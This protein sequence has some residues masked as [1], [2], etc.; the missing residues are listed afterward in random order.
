MDRSATACT[1]CLPKFKL[2]MYVENEFVMGEENIIEGTLLQLPV[3]GFAWHF[4]SWL[5]I[6]HICTILLV[7]GSSRHSCSPKRC[8]WSN[9]SSILYCHLA[10]LHR[11]DNKLI[12]LTL[13]ENYLTLFSP[14]SKS[15]FTWM[16]N[17]R[18]RRTSLTVIFNII[19]WR[20]IRDRSDSFIIA[21]NQWL[22]LLNPIQMR[23]SYQVQYKLSHCR[24]SV[25]SCWAQE[26][27]IVA[28]LLREILSY[29]PQDFHGKRSP[30]STL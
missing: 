27:N 16:Q 13:G 12:T 7:H 18:M 24:S 3:Y 20:Q 22:I 11:T 1:R 17:A 26:K 8:T 19:I 9:S 29:S 4:Y 23:S 21:K 30:Y 28:P 5:C 10:S 15:A 6:L 2:W 25:E 14:K